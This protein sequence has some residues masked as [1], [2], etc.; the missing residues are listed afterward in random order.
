MAGLSPSRISAKVAASA[1]RR[2]I[3]LPVRT[4]RRTCGT[5]NANR[6]RIS[7]STMPL[8][9]PRTTVRYVQ[10]VAVFSRT[11]FAVSIQPCGSAIR[12]KSCQ[13]ETLRRA[14]DPEHLRSARPRNQP[15][16]PPYRISRRFRKCCWCSNL[17]PTMTIRTASGE[18]PASCSAAYFKIA[19]CLQS[20]V[21]LANAA[22]GDVHSPG[23]AFLI[24]RIERF[25][26]R[27]MCPIRA[28]PWYSSLS[29]TIAMN[30]SAADDARV[31]H[32]SEQ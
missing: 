25:T 2:S 12:E 24:P 32:D 17:S 16:S 11:A 1:C 30:R 28:R 10:L 6:L 3:T 5:I 26:A 19:C 14:R 9:L 4:A 15:N 18:N 31:G 8:D 27:L 23:A 22:S 13:R 7:S 21:P 29:L 20:P